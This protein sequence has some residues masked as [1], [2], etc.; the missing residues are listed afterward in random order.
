MA[1][2]LIADDDRETC[3]FIAELLSSP[4]RRI[5][6]ESDPAEALRRAANERFDAVISDINLN[7][8]QSGLD[9]LRAARR[10]NPRCQVVLI[11]G[12]G[13]LET[14]VEAVRAGAFDYISKPFNIAQVKAVVE[15]A[16]AQAQ[17]PDRGEIR[18]E[19]A[20]A[21]GL[22]GRTAPMLEVYK[23]IA[24]AADA[25]A[26]VLIIGESGT[27]KELVAKAIHAH[28]RRAQK[29][30]VAVNCG[31]IAETLLESELFGHAKGSFTGA[32]SDSK[33]FFEQARGGTIFLDEIGETSPALQVKLLRAIEEGEI[34]PVG[35]ARAFALD[36]RVVAATNVELERA[37]AEGRFRQDLFYRV[38]VVVIRVPPLRERR[39]DIPL[40][41][42]AFL[43]QA[44]ART[45][46][47]RAL[48][49][50]ALEALAAH[51]WP[52]N[53]R[54][55]ENTIERLVLFSPGTTIDIADLPAG[56][57]GRSVPVEERLFDGLPTLDEVERR[58]LLHVL[59]A[60]KGNRT[61]AADVLGIDRRTLYRMAG[62]FGIDL[63]G[64]VER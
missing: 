26:P 48:S 58:Y 19:P 37:V 24:L 42:E 10:R 62:R 20:L 45:G 35:A 36:V 3:Q 44:C 39:A 64:D 61:R 18:R 47:E 7:A 63:A 46:R 57:G 16:L 49:Q 5:V 30:F 15:R 54:E 28:G 17:A 21:G 25:E 8:P 12:F 51:D 1:D 32:V 60:V 56:M 9:V 59:D 43:R 55:L 4:D 6:F 27:G 41:V 22:L 2:I 40:L 52:G 11:S 34:R 31:A 53:V 33:G 38:S 23:Q 50:P 14:A 29:P 13:T